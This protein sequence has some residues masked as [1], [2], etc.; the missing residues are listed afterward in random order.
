[1]DQRILHA[2]FYLLLL[3][4]WVHS[5]KSDYFLDRIK[6]LLFLMEMHS[7]FCEVKTEFYCT[8]SSFL[9]QKITPL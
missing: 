5:Q 9:L 4:A 7:V 8:W 6:P 2:W 1:L 3:M